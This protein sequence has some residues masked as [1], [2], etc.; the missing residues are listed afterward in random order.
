[1]IRSSLVGVVATASLAV[2]L[3]AAPAAAA[4]ACDGVAA[5]DR[6]VWTCTTTT[7]E[8]VRGA[9]SS[10]SYYRYK[11]QDAQPNGWPEVYR[12]LTARSQP[13]TVTETVTVATTIGGE[14]AG[15]TTSTR[16]ISSEQLPVSCFAQEAVLNSSPS[17]VSG[18]PLQECAHYGLFT[19]V[20]QPVQTPSA[21]E[22]CLA[23]L[24]QVK[25]RSSCTT[26]SQAAG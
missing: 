14:S 5:Q 16:V 6:N 11:I 26:T 3:G 19:G 8:T 20:A 12:T 15:T 23:A 25:G 17:S 13:E 1:L 7:T 24:A 4:P 9:I 18:A 2:G 10:A 21:D 22:A